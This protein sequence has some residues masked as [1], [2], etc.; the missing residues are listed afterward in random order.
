MYDR[1]TCEHYVDP[2]ER[3]KNKRLE[4]NVFVE[5]TDFENKTI[6]YSIKIGLHAL[7]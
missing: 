6:K 4:E 1:D 2:I 5:D 7:G 3:N